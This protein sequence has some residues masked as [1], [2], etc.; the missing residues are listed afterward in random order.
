MRILFGLAMLAAVLGLWLLS[1]KGFGPL[2]RKLGAAALS[3]LLAAGAAGYL[4]LALNSEISALQ[5]SE[6]FYYASQ[7]DAAGRF[8]REKLAGTD[9][10]LIA[11]PGYRDDLRLP[12]FRE[13][14]CRAVGHDNVELAPL[15]TSNPE[16]PLYET[17]KSDD[18]DRLQQKFPEADVFVS[19]VGLPSDAMR[20]K[21]IRQGGPGKKPALLL[22]GLGEVP[23]R[24]L[25]EAIRSGRV[26][27]AITLRTEQIDSDRLAPRNPEEAFALRYRLITLENVAG[28]L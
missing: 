1:R 2:K 18:F 16:L 26:A 22:I 14:F 19:L 8:I 25:A 10:V 17:M 9:I 7:A 20:M 27:G 5:D 3:L 11:D 24:Q 6:T 21:M 23:R 4:R 28:A 15:E 12:G 13:A